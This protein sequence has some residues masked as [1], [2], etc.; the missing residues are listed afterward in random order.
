MTMA[1]HS[2][3][4]SCK[5]II[6]GMADCDTVTSV[7]EYITDATIVRKYMSGGCKRGIIVIIVYT[8]STSVGEISYNAT[9]AVS[10]CSIVSLY[11]LVILFI[12][13]L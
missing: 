9:I 13:Q 5:H 1:V 7:G 8:I 2:A 4:S 12:R 6:T 11:Y 3:A 10:G